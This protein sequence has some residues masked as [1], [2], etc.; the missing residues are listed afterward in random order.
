[1]PDGTNR[2][3]KVG[4]ISLVASGLLF[5]AKAVLEWRI[6]PPPSSGA[7][8]LAW[9]ASQNVLFAAACEVFFVAVIL[10]IPAIVA[11]YESLAGTHRSSA[12]IGCGLLALT[13]PLLCGLLIVQ[14]RI[15]FPVY[16]LRIRSPDIAEFVVALYYGGLHVVAELQA[17]ATVV[18][19]LALLRSAY[20]RGLASL[21]FATGAF[22]LIGAYPWATGP[23]L[24]FVCSVFF[25]AW[26]VAVGFRLYRMPPAAL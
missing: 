21:G 1:M 23:L 2:L 13:L 24:G 10:L 3:Y 22:D 12:A 4:G 20:G 16:A 14:G 11:L 5:L 18:L 19:S 25:A 26:F 7:E 15:A 17:V 6:G 8:I 9:M